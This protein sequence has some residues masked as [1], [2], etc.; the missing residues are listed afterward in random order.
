M[1]DRTG[2]AALLVQKFGAG[3]TPDAI[4]AKL[5]KSA[6][7]SLPTVSEVDGQT[8]QYDMFPLGAGYLDGMGTLNH[9]DAT[10]TD[11]VALSPSAVYKCGVAGGKGC[12]KVPHAANPVFSSA[13]TSGRP[14][15]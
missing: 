9:T 2:A 5:M 7:K 1:R 15:G 13:A 6:T 12:M 14:G 8:V 4:Q 11:K 3:I 10:P